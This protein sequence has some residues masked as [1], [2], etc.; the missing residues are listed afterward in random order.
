MSIQLSVQ[1]ERT[2]TRQSSAKGQLPTAGQRIAGRTSSETGMQQEGPAEGLG[3][4]LWG[5]RRAAEG[6]G[7]GMGLLCAWE[8][9]ASVGYSVPC[10]AIWKP[11]Q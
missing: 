10:K 6:K 3:G 1:G 4:A 7:R 2:E 5:Y 9:G 8:C 11:V